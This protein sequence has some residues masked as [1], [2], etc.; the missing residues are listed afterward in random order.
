MHPD[1]PCF[2]YRICLSLLAMVL[3]LDVLANTVNDPKYVGAKVCGGC[4]SQAYEDWQGSHH[5][6]AMQ[7]ATDETVL[8][9]FNQARFEYNGIT[10]TFF[11]KGKE[12]WVNTDGSDGKLTDFKIQYTFGVTPLQQYLIGFDD[13]RFQ[14]LGIAWDS[15]SKEQGGQR[16]YHLYPN[17]KVDHQDIL[18][19]T[20]FS[21]NW[22]ARCADC[23]STNLQK[24]Y[25]P[26]KNQYE[27]TW[28]EI[29]VACESCHG[30]GADHLAW[31]KTPLKKAAPK[32]EGVIER[33]KGFKHN[34][35]SDLW[36]R[37]ATED[38]ASRVGGAQSQAQ[39]NSCAPCHSR[40]GTIH[41]GDINHEGELLN[42]F[43]PSLIETPIYH[44]DGQIQ[45]E[46]YVYGS[47]TQSKM[48]QKGVVCSNCH[49]PH[50][51]K[52]RVQENG[53]CAQCH[54]PQKFNQKTHH[55]HENN[56]GAMC[57]NCHMPETTYMV[58]DPRRDHSIRIPRPDLSKE[59][60]VPNA[61]NQCHENKS[62]NWA[63]NNYKKW[64]AKPSKKSHYGQIFSQ[65]QSG[66]QQALPKL[67]ALAENTA[68]PVIVRASAIAML[69]QYPNQQAVSHA[70]LQL[71]ASEPLMRLA[72][73][74]SL[75]ILN[76]SQR[77]QFIWPFI[78]DPVKAVRLEAVRLLAGVGTNKKVMAS[79]TAQQQQDFKLT[80]K[81][82]IITANTHSDAPSGQ[83][84]LGVMY[85]ALGQFDQALLA[86][87]RALVIEADFTPA[88]LNI[89]DVYR[90]LNQ[91]NKGIDAL[92]RAININSK[93]SA[94]HF[95][96]GLTYIRLKK[97]NKALPFL[98]AAITTPGNIAHYHYVYAVALYESGQV[99]LAIRSL[100]ASLKRYPG[101]VQIKAALASYL[102]AR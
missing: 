78:T 61:C 37:K 60:G 85:Q 25:S 62:I 70:L 46:D 41:N 15:R 4:H 38:T 77:L 5:D 69:D 28:F 17:E 40:R 10:S 52:L 58:V 24:N 7:H 89:A 27:T 73:L 84:K 53:L 43:L 36:Q 99:K 3:C 102:N 91:E 51:L 49:N 59:L 22:N 93:Q 54:N 97:I 90:Q 6:Q 19:W 98:K 95:A 14:S 92:K 94:T 31:S 16:W 56:N 45:D 82:Y 35:K 67:L 11:K 81:E 65:A 80:V 57:A 48:H 74:R 30:P 2:G 13:G 63:L 23:H 100:Q 101:H 50:S 68:N 42:G 96:L 72:A 76:L 8:G 34:L 20:R 32:I 39:V 71:Q 29:N 21:Q 83:S 88:L 9:N 1:T 44:V 47:F 66:Q 87:E 79:L 64:Y 18:H 12:F 75:E 55:H 26:E 86:Y 33:N